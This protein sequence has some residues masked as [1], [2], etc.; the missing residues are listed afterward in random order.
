MVVP[1]YIPTNSLS[2]LFSMPSPEFIVCRLF[3]DGRSDQCEVIPHYCFDLCFSDFDFS[4]FSC[5]FW[6]SEHHNFE[7]TLEVHS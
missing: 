2:S 5:A 4:I 7:G 3:D 6:P 1:I